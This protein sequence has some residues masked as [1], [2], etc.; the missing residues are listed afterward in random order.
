MLDLLFEQA[1]HT[2]ALGT[3]WPH[4]RRALAEWMVDYFDYPPLVLGRMIERDIRKHPERNRNRS[5]MDQ[6]R[7]RLYADLKTVRPEG[8]ALQTVARL[9]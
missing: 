4:Y 9:I 6:L 2:R 5:F 1:A 3:L 8:T 7:A